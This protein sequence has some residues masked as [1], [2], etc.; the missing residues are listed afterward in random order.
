MFVPKK[1]FG[2]TYV[3]LESGFFLSNMGTSGLAIVRWPTVIYSPV[4]VVVAAAAAAVTT[5]IFTQE[6]PLTEGVFREVQ[7]L[8]VC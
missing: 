3:R 1:K 8:K 5:T 6:A 2:Q 7:K 4:V